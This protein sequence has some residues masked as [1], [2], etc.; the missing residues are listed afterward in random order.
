MQLGTYRQPSSVC[1]PAPERSPWYRFVD[2]KD[3]QQLLRLAELFDHIEDVLVW[4][5]D[6]DGRYCWV[7]RAFLINYV[8]TGYQDH[9]QF[10][11]GPQAIVGKTDYDLS[12]AFLA[13]QFRLDDEHVLTGKRIVNR[14]ELVG[15]PDGLTVWNVTNKIPLFD[16]DGEIIGTAGITRRLNSPTPDTVPGSEFG[17]V[18]AYM[19]DH[20]RSPITNV[21][22]AR[23]AHMSVRAFERK[24]RGSF[25]LTPQKYLRKLQMRMASRALV[26]SSESLAKV[27]LS[28]GFA[29]QS[30][31]TREFRRH[32]GRTPRDYREHYGQGAGAAAPGTNSAA[33]AQ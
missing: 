3:L 2:M 27:A 17:A 11:A 1:R 29:D 6:R 26:Y 15:Q 22:L 9:G 7:N 16:M 23:L 31:F 25:H 28:C 14:I 33:G 20:Y 10:A 24:F 13:D 5:K 4:V 21:E 32:F 8:T 30:H 12:P 19:R 18:L